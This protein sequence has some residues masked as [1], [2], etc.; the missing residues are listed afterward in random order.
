MS[1]NEQLSSHLCELAALR[2]Q[3][4]IVLGLIVQ[5]LIDRPEDLNEIRD[6]AIEQLAYFEEMFVGIKKAYKVKSKAAKANKH[7]CAYER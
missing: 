5:D 6:Y 7:E 4:H 1:K 2:R 3:K